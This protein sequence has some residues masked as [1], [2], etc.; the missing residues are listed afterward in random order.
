MIIDE[1]S[2]PGFRDPDRR[3]K[4]EAA[5]PTIE[6]MITDEMKAQGLPG[7][8][9][10]IV[11]DGELAYAKGFGVTDLESKRVPDADTVYRIGSI[12]KSFTGL[13]LLALRDDGVLQLDEPLAKWIPEAAQIVYP[14]RDARHITLRQVAT[15][16]SGLPRD[17]TFDQENDP[18]EDTVV[19]S[20]VKLPLERAPGMRHSY[21]NLGFG[22]LGI[23][24]A[25]A[26]KAPYHDIV[27][28][29]I[30]AP[31][32]MTATFWD[33]AQVPAGKLAPPQLPGPANPSPVPKLARLGAIDGAGGIYSSLRDMAKYVAFQLAAYPPRSDEDA[34]R[35]RRATVRE[36]HSTGFA[37]GVHLQPPVAAVTY[38]FGW[39]VRQSCR[40]DDLVGHNGAVDSYRAEIAFSPS[41]GV[42][43]I[44]M[45]NF[46]M[47]NTSVFVDR[48]L[49]EL[50]K[51]GALVPREAA[52][53]RRLADAMQKLLAVY[54]QWDEAT[55]KAILG[56][57][58]DPREQGEL[59]M[60]KQLHGACS[61]FTLAR[62]ESP[63]VGTFDVTC[64]R[65][66]FQMQLAADAQGK[67]VGF[68]GFSKG[69]PP[70]P[71][72][73]KMARE[74][75]ALHQK[76]DDKI[77]AKYLAKAAPSETMKQLAAQFHARHGD[78]KIV[79][80]IHEAFDWGYQL[81]CQ[82]EDVEMYLVTAPD[83]PAHVVDIHLR[84]VRGAP[85]KCD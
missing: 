66:S 80:P 65:G 15:H 40:F 3:K 51:T 47:A 75:L 16:T 12:T 19:K 21:S 27:A 58:I 62:Q 39:G 60:Y 37:A 71:T 46:G 32:G 36:A 54:N 49:L 53:S 38:G 11:I 43:V 34:G 14:A 6:K 1:P 76:W 84:P 18:T 64:E 33:Q 2:A 83:D 72:F 13:A 41:R 56:R 77:Y 73:E 4:L 22:L 8:S 69:V 31:L 63:Q 57:P 59:A 50:D 10:G 44:A 52:P 17:S 78:C 30:F 61:S 42:G 20:L 29:R 7:L 25:H 5:F 48:T 74:L 81:A 9:F 67:I 70:P 85:A 24:I 82:K 68:A 45:T 26:A 79:A 55:L 28:A 23:V 35:I